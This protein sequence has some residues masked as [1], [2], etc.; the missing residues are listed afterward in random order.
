[1]H[2]AFQRGVRRLGWDERLG[3][4]FEWAREAIHI[5][6]LTIDYFS[7]CDTLVERFD[8]IIP[9][10]GVSQEPFHS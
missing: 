6:V 1:V 9:I 2:R 7:G 4:L 10:G 3:W 8:F 5:L